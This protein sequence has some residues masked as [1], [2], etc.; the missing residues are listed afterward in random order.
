MAQ[1]TLFKRVSG[2]AHP[3]SVAEA[4]DEVVIRKLQ[5][6]ASGPAAAWD[7]ANT[8]SI[9]IGGGAAQTSITIGGGAAFTGLT[10]GKAGVTDTHLGDVRVNGDLVVMGTTTAVN[11]TN[12]NV[13]DNTLY[14]NNGYTTVAALTG[15]LAVNYL[16]TA[17]ND[18]VAAGGFTAGVPA[19]S[20][21]T[22]A[23]TAATTF[24]VGEFIQVSG[25][26]VTANNGLFEV[27]SHAANVLTIR[28]VGVTGT[29]EDF[30]QNQFTTSAGAT[31]AIRKV[32][33]SV[34]RAGSDG[35]WEEAQGSSTGLT[36]SDLSASVTSL[37]TAYDNSTSPATITTN[38]TDDEIL[39]TGTAGLRITATGA[40]NTV[41]VGFGFEV[42]T[43]GA[44]RLLADAASTISVDSANLNLTTTTSGTVAVS[45]AGGVTVGAASTVSINSTGGALNLGNNANAFAINIGTGAAART[46]TVGNSTGATAVNLDAGTGGISLDASGASN[47]SVAGANLTLATTTSGALAVTSAGVLDVDATGALSLNSSGAAINVGDDANAFAIN[48][49]TGAAARTVT[50]GNGTGATSL[51]LNAGTGAINIGTNAVAHTTTIGNATGASAIQITSGTGEI[52][53][54]ATGATVDIN[55]TARGGTITLNESGQ[56]T[57]T[58]FTATSIIG[59]LNELVGGA[60]GSVSNT[61]TNNTGSAIAAGSGVY[62]T[63]TASE[64]AKATASTD[65][66]AAQYIGVAVSSIADTASGLIASEGVRNVAFV[67]SL[68]LANGNEVFLSTTAGLF[69]NVAPV[70]SGNVVLSVGFVKDAAAYTGASGDLASVQLVRGS[71]SVV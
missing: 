17:T 9:V 68:T 67:A 20:N 71:K 64:I 48:I 22:I 30:T 31:G 59:A 42:D 14:L 26:T 43:T 50:I 60:A 23:T 46:I 47:F 29:V 2:K 44:Y 69:T 28:G 8:T 57:L 34:L 7:D 6:S 36:F 11:S 55:F 12:V 5:R 15:G 35:L 13:G 62:I 24:A 19:T 65:V 61:Y 52:T 53:L 10:L 16:P 32:N 51:V 37:Q 3:T 18:T 63:T 49:G 1:V 33:V 41:S 56:T 39:I 40:D 38:A 58:G 70:A 4:A 21:P 45:S 25:A 54:T 66:A 27:L